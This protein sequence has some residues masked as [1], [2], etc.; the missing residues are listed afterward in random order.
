MLPDHPFPD[1]RATSGVDDQARHQVAQIEAAIES[2]GESGQVV[3][4]VL[5]VFE[6]VVS[7]GQRGLEVTQHSVHPQ[8][9]R[10]ISRLAVPDDHRLVGAS[11]GGDG[12]E[13][14]QTVADDCAAWGQGRLGPLANGIGGESADQVELQESWP[15]LVVQRQG[16]HERDLVLRTSARFTAHAL[17][18]EVGVVNLN[19]ALESVDA[20]ARGH[21]AVDLV[22]QQPGGGVAHAELALH[23]QRRQTRLGLADQVDGQEPRG[24]RQLG[25]LEQAAGG[26]RGLMPAADALEQTP[27]AVTNHVVRVAA[28]AWAAEAAGPAGGFQR[29]GAVRLGAKAAKELGQRHAGLELDSVEGHRVRSVIGYT[30]VTRPVAHHMSLAEAGF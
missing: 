23:R 4:G 27:R 9:L 15:V 28:A 24:Q 21:G 17:A 8:E 5:A 29:R 16:G 25:V 20:L 19:D 1:G 26:Q 18:T 6:R 10:Q 13:T 12:G 3:G 30:Q 14:T 7:A 22:V 11:C 2:V